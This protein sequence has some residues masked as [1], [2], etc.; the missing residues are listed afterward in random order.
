MLLD[1]SSLRKALAQ[2]AQGLANY[3]TQPQN[4]LLRDGVIQRFEYCYE[5]AH[6]MLKR[7]LE[8]TEASGDTVDALS[9]PDMVRLGF[10]RGL[11]AQSFDVWQLYRTARNTTS[12]GYN[13]HKAAEVFAIIPAFLADAEFLLAQLEARLGLIDAT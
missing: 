4:E 2:L 12:H 1:V 9:F 6:K 11:L 5:L 7:Y 10:E 3:S 13:A 8:K